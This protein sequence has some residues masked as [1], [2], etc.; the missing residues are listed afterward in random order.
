MSCHL[1][2]DPDKLTPM[3]FPPGNART[4]QDPKMCRTK[5]VS[6]PAS[7]Q[8]DPPVRRETVS[9]AFK[10][11]CPVQC[12]W[13]KAC[14]GTMLEVLAGACEATEPVGVVCLVWSIGPL[15]MLN[16]ACA[17]GRI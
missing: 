3:A 15:R 6:P 9:L 12:W 8:R 2:S 4:A 1:S 17:K 14:A 5:A 16:M 11:A 7:C 10:D 13:A